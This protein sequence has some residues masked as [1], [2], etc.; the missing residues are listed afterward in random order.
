MIPPDAVLMLAVAAIA[1]ASG[2]FYAYHRASR[3]LEAAE[4]ELAR[5]DIS[6]DRLAEVQHAIEVLSTQYAQLAESHDFMARILSDRLPLGTLPRNPT[7]RPE[8][9]PH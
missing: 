4:R 7:P 1:G 5:D 3:R 6:D 2:P 9:T 8:I